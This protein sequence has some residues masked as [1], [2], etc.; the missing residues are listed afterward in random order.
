MHAKIFSL[1]YNGILRG[2]HVSIYMAEFFAER[3]TVQTRGLYIYEYIEQAQYIRLYIPSSIDL[4][5]RGQ[6][7]FLNCCP[8]AA[9]Q[10]SNI[11]SKLYTLGRGK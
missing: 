2:E 8:W 3:E 5:A 9:I 11:F 6:C 1:Q 7:D 10:T 4:P